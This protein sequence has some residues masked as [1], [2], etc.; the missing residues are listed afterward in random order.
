MIEDNP[1]IVEIIMATYGTSRRGCFKDSGSSFSSMLFMKE[2]G[3]WIEWNRDYGTCVP[4]LEPRFIGFFAIAS[5]SQGD[6]TVQTDEIVRS[7]HTGPLPHA[8]SYPRE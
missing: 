1:F 2:D 8:S 6:P 4:E 3:N 5:E 7:P